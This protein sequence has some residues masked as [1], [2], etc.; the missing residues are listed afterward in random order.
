MVIRQFDMCE[1]FRAIIGHTEVDSLGF[2]SQFNSSIFRISV[3]LAQVIIFIRIVTL[4]C[5]WNF[6][7]DFS[8]SIDGVSGGVGTSLSVKLIFD[9]LMNDTS[10][11]TLPAT[12]PLIFS[13]LPS[14]LSLCENVRVENGLR[15][16]MI[17]CGNCDNIRFRVSCHVDIDR[18]D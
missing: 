6:S 1:C 10:L 17:T 13:F 8:I 12:V 9:R 7:F 16:L 15:V 14:V 4:T 5:L 3:S 2:I 11:D 18:L